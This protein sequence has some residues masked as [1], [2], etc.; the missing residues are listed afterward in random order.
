MLAVRRFPA[1]ALL[2]L[3]GFG[4]LLPA[5]SA[6]AADTSYELTPGWFVID[7]TTKCPGQAA[8]QLTGKHAAAFI[9]SWYLASILG[10]LTE[11]KPPPSLPKCTFLARDKIQGGAYQFH[12]FYVSQGKKAWVGLP[13]QGIGPGAYV[14]ADKW[15]IATPRA[16]P[17]FHGLIDPLPKTVP[18]TTTTTTTIAPAAKDTSSGSS[19]APWIIVAVVAAVALLG[20]GAVVVRRRASTS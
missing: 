18:T 16:T 7:A 10:T 20:A 1:V 14:P 19:S 11:E 2:L 12:A 13:R 5:G 17:A 15:Y 9:E 3:T 8:R 6:S 4:V